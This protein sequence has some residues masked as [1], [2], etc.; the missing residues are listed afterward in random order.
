[1]GDQYV[2]DLKLRR[3]KP[4]CHYCPAAQ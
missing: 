2:P 1:L 3:G 4:G